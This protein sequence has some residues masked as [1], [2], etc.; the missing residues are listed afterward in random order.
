MSRYHQYECRVKTIKRNQNQ[1]DKKTVNSRIK[2]KFDVVTVATVFYYTI[3][4][5]A[6][7]SLVLNAWTIYLFKSFCLSHSR[8]R[9]IFQEI[10][11]NATKKVLK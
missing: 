10:E 7:V 11:V 1:K 6:I 4:K 8:T 5:N 2:F 9:F 3:P